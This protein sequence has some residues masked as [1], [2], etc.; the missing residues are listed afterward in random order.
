[1]KKLPIALL[2]LICATMLNGCN[3]EKLSGSEA[4]KMLL[5]EERLDAEELK[6][7]KIEFGSSSK[8]RL[9]PNVQMRRSR[10]IAEHTKP[11]NEA[12]NKTGV[13][14]TR[15]GNKVTWSNF[16]EYSNGVSYFEG[17]IENIGKSTENGAKLIEEAKRKVDANGVWV[18]GL[19][20][21]RLLKVTA[22][23]DLVMRKSK[24][25]YQI[26]SH[27]LNEQ[28]EDCY[29]VFNGTIG[30]QH[31]MRTRKVSDYRYE[32]SYVSDNGEF[33][34][35]FVADKS[36]GY[37]MILSPV[38]EYQF[39]TTVL[40]DDMC[41]EVVSNI[42]EE[43][44]CAL[45]VI[46]ADQACDILRINY[47]SF[48]FSA[49]AIANLD[50]MTTYASDSQIINQSDYLSGNDNFLLIYDK[51]TKSYST[52]GSAKID[53]HLGNGVTL[54]EGDTYAN[55]AVSFSRAIVGGSADGMIGSF[56]VD[57]SGRTIDEKIAN[58]EKF[59]QE[60][61]IQFVRDYNTVIKSIKTAYLDAAAASK[62]IVWNDI[63]I[64]SVEEYKKAYEIGE[65]ELNAFVKEFEDV[66]DNVTLSR[67][68]QGK[69]DRNTS[70]PYITKATFAA[71]YT[72]NMVNINSATAKVED[73]VLFEKGKKYNMQYALAQYSEENEGYFDLIPLGVENSAY[74]PYNGE[75]EFTLTTHQLSFALPVPTAGDYELVT[76]IADEDGIRVSRPQPVA[77]ENVEQG[78]ISIHNYTANVYKT[79]ENLL[80]L[81]SVIN[82]N[83]VLQIEDPKLTYTYQELHQMLSTEAFKFGVVGSEKVEVLLANN[84]WVPLTGNED[85]LIAGT[86]RLAFINSDSEQV[87]VSTSF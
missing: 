41:Y 4:A 25:A 77:F 22:N 59:I 60:T 48:E 46:S 33:T 9:N 70:F 64:N 56:S 27:T 54:K 18:N 67:N 61:G 1:M 39:S 71:D 6:N 44:I 34:H 16:E 12:K 14:A 23:R 85:L 53:V 31:G 21:D 28:G 8:R 50:S 40:K 68:Q 69:L 83:V 76:Y 49:G 32:Y 55:G 52:T 62:S 26:V 78:E 19:I 72:D 29:D 86:Y 57:V 45:N 42:G 37:W 65:N 51:D 10:T 17:F 38:N 84:V 7:S 30:K 3:R 43:E 24:E 11:I 36:R 74:V 2:T 81:T 80:G 63:N 66:K 82:D 79:E 5:A 13:E 20:Y 47:S 75:D 15:D 58:L 35:H 87:Y 73:F